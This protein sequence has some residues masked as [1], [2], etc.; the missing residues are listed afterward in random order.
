MATDKL[1]LAVFVQV[2]LGPFSAM[3][4]CMCPGFVDFATPRLNNLAFWLS[5]LS[6]QLLVVVLAFEIAGL[7]LANAAVDL[8]NIVLRTCRI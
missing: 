2:M 5:V 6:V 4:I 1:A 7:L 3:E 8:A